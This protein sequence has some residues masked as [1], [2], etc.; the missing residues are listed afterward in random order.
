MRT[1]FTQL[2][3]LAF[4]VAVAASPAR[5]A[6]PANFMGDCT[7]DEAVSPG[8]VIASCNSF[9]SKTLMENFRDGYDALALYYRAKAYERLGKLAQAQADL[10][11]AIKLQPHADPKFWSELGD[12]LE[13]MGQPGQMASA[14]DAMLK[15]NPK[16]VAFLNHACRIRALRGVQPELGFDNCTQA[17]LLFPDDATMLDS[18]CLIRY[19][20]GQ[21]ANAIADCDAALRLDDTMAS[22]L[23]VRGLADIHLGYADLGKADL[24]AATAIDPKIADTYAGYGL[25]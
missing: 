20:L 16:E 2:L 25:K 3:G 21:F 7:D 17:L 11:Q 23:Y 18:R 12:V 15:A 4:L 8:A 9:V 13:K 14:L 5:A 10:L 6:N 22:S 1:G 19:R 24:A